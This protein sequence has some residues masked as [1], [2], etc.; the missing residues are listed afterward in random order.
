MRSWSN[1]SNAELLNT[2]KDERAHI[3]SIDCLAVQDMML[4][5]PRKHVP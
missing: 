2:V 3:F 5:L 4:K 1:V